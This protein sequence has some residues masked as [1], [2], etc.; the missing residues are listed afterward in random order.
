MIVI[1]RTPQIVEDAL[2][3]DIICEIQLDNS[4]EYIPFADSVTLKL[5]MRSSTSLCLP[6]VSLMRALK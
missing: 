2:Y 6:T 1:L 3:K 5:A 4:L